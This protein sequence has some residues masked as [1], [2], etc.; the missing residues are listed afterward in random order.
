M[1]EGWDRA[2]CDELECANA[3]PRSRYSCGLGSMRRICAVLCRARDL[4]LP[5]ACL[6][7]GAALRRTHPNVL[8][9]T[10]DT[11]RADHLGSY[12]DANA[13]TPNL[14]ALAKRGVRFETALSHV[15]L[16]GPVAHV[17]PDRPHAARTWVPEQ[18]RLRP[19]ADTAHGCRGLQAGRLSHGGV[20]VGVPSRSS[21]RVRSRLRDLRRPPAPRQRPAADAVCRTP[22]RRDNRCGRSA[23]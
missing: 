2:P 3:S 7:A 9:V 18:R 5:A 4:W 21:L 10:I 17:D 16:T 19:R 23:G 15:P 8:L 1:T 14:D 13:M 11:L 20:R 12:G 22:R 6:R